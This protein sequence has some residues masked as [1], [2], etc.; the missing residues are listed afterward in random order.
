MLTK[1]L[2]EWEILLSS[3]AERAQQ[4][5]KPMPTFFREFKSSESRRVSSLLSPVFDRR[6]L[7][8]YLAFSSLFVHLVIIQ[9]KT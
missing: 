5:G 8:L 1:T 3:K 7:Y 2:P 4:K 6:L 9:H